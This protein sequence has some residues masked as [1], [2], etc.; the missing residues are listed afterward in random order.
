[1]IDERR[2]HEI[3]LEGPV[4]VEKFWS[5]KMIN[6]AVVSPEDPYLAV[7]GALS[8]YHPFTNTIA[9]SRGVKGSLLARLVIHELGHAV[10]GLVM[11]L[12]KPP[13]CLVLYEMFNT[14]WDIL[15]YIFDPFWKVGTKLQFIG[16]RWKS[17]KQ[18]VQRVSNE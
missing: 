8:A 10:G 9:I 17:L 12:V 18:Y 4:M 6:I 1:M 11:F 7:Q 5:F 13:L 2:I 3:L 14:F 16:M 15:W